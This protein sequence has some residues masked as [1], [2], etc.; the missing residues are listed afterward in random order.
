M[1]MS[2]IR[3]TDL[4]LLQM[5]SIMMCTDKAHWV[6]YC[7]FGLPTLSAA[8]VQNDNADAS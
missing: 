6:E 3:N 1:Q 4:M 7:E 2:T 8:K 5:A